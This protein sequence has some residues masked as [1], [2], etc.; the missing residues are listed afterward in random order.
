MEDALLLSRQN[1]NSPSLVVTT[2]W[3]LLLIFIVFAVQNTSKKHSAE[4]P[5][6]VLKETY[7]SYPKASPRLVVFHFLCDNA[8]SMELAQA[9]METMKNFIEPFVTTWEKQTIERCGDFKLLSSLPNAEQ[10]TQLFHSRGAH[11]LFG[12]KRGGFECFT[13]VYECAEQGCRD[14]INSIYPPSQLKQATNLRIS[15]HQSAKKHANVALRK[16]SLKDEV[17]E[18]LLNP[19]ANESDPCVLRLYNEQKLDPLV[20]RS[21]GE[22]E[23]FCTSDIEDKESIDANLDE[24]EPTECCHW[25]D[26]RSS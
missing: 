3:A 22:Y 14:E 11:F 7:A 15:S 16:C 17:K 5:I 23:T 8:E 12:L 20:P 24:C 6:G 19:G 4:A 2:F 26:A 13:K 21:L 1:K 10:E 25:V 18:K 9:L